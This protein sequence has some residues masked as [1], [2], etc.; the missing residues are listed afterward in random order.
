MMAIMT[1]FRLSFRQGANKFLHVYQAPSAYACLDFRGELYL[2]AGRRSLRL[3]EFHQHEASVADAKSSSQHGLVSL[4]RSR[5]DV[6][7]FGSAFAL[8]SGFALMAG[9]FGAPSSRRWSE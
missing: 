5:G 6:L 7:G 2:G 3:G 9:F 8:A 1:M 4:A